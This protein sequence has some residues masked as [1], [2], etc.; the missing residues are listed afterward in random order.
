MSNDMISFLWDNIGLGLAICTV[1]FT[2]FWIIPS[3][4]R[5]P[6]VTPSQQ[7]KS[8]TTADKTHGHK[9]LAGNQIESASNHLAH[10]AKP[11]QQDQK[12]HNLRILYGTQT[13]TARSAFLHMIVHFQMTKRVK[14]TYTTKQKIYVRARDMHTQTR[15]KPYDRDRHMR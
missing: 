15:R 4:R 11:S 6:S 10:K 2:F 5:S 9:A 1:A 3:F 12:T 7:Q 8:K 13:G 14:S